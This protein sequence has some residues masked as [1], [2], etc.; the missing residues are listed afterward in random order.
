MSKEFVS[1][2][3]NMVNPYEKEETSKTITEI[4]KDFLFKQKIDL[5]KGFYDVGIKC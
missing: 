1:G 4:I 5:K 2:I 3:S